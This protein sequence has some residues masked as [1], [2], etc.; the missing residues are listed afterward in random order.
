LS[1]QTAKQYYITIQLVQ[2]DQPAPNKRRRG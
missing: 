2:E 1:R